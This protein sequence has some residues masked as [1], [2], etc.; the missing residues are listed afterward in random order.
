MKAQ[1][2]RSLA[3]VAVICCLAAGCAVERHP[4]VV[5][6]S[7]AVVVPKSPPPARHEVLPSPPDETAVW[8]PG[9]WKFHADHWFWMDGHWEEPPNLRTAWVDG[10]W[11]RTT[12][13]W[14][15]TPGHWD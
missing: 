9:F 6:P 7:G 4:V 13:G 3:G 10:H 11:R 8:V 5:T 14:V 12:Q 2:L 15:W 1:T